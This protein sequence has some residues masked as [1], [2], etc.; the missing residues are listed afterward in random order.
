MVVASCAALLSTGGAAIAQATTPQAAQAV[1]T[2]PQ[3]P[4]WL[5]PDQGCT[6]AST[7]LMR[8]TPWS[9]PM[10]GL[11]SAQKLSLGDGVTVG[12]VGTGVDV[13][14]AAFKSRISGDGKDDCVGHGTFAA[15]LIAAAPVKGVGFVGVAP[16]ARIFGV[17]ATTERGVTDADSIAT[18]I[19]S[20]VDAGCGVVLVSVPYGKPS[21]QMKSA[22]QDALEKDVVVVA[23]AAGG[24]QTSAP[25]YPGAL[26]GVV[27][28]GAVGVDGAP[29]PSERKATPAT[30]DLVAPGD[31]LISLGPGGGHFTASGDP[32]AAAYVAGAAAL[33]RA[34]DTSLS[35]QEVVTR[36]QSTAVRPA[37][38]VPGPLAGYG[39]LDLVAAVSGVNDSDGAVTTSQGVHIRPYRVPEPK[40]SVSP[41][42][43]WIV[44]GC[45]MLV[46]ALTAA[47]AAA[48]PRGRARRWQTGSRS[49]GDDV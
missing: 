19:T 36:L 35:A 31:R 44:A 12:V 23:P 2:V 22:V 10:I 29:Y 40:P 33:V 13:R 37:G 11:R 39:M 27:A 14:A 20:A 46:A 42:S 1:D 15:G 18:A 6:A 21:K 9:Q 30:P 24:D 7:R 8:K 45:A 38:R 49:V 28:V 41:L 43:A 5:G 17:R 34:H 26:P 32:V 4:E 3:V 48:V 47:V 25:A 16:H